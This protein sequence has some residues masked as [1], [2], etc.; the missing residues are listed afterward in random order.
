[1]SRYD[2]IE[3][4]YRSSEM[5]STE[6][7]FASVRSHGFNDVV[8]GR[9]LAGNY[10]LLR[11]HYSEYFEQAL[12]VRRL[13]SLEFNKAF[14]HVD[15]LV[16]PVTLSDAPSFN[17]FSSCDN[18]TQTAKNDYCPQPANLAGLPA[19]SIPVKLSKKSLPIAMQVIGPFGHDNKVID[20]C[21]WLENR[22]HFPQ[23]EL[24]TQ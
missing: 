19:A 9:I 13:I 2:G 3:F 4:G 1:M 21:K 7:L 20:F 16:T 23:P 18:R 12:K 17:E 8:K 14:Q 15:L 24:V 10:F 5:S 22:I 11:E 6:A